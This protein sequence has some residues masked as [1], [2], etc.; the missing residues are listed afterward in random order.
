[1]QPSLTA[2]NRPRSLA[3]LEIVLIFVIRVGMLGGLLL[4]RLMGHGLTIRS[5][6]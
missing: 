5:S 6:A 2:P 1:M 3:N 4:C